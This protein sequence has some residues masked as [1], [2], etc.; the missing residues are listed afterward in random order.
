MCKLRSVFRPEFLNRVD[1]TVLFK[2][3]SKG[4]ILS[5]VELQVNELARR[6][7]DH[8][9]QLEVTQEAREFIAGAAYDPVYGARPLK[10]YLQQEV[11]TPIARSIVGGSRADGC[12]RVSL[13]AGGLSVS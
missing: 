11:E 8:G 12:V 1:D 4:E 6:L 2:P 9:L 7:D 13:E 5:I 3:L 10:R